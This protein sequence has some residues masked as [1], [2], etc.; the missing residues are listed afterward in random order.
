MDIIE[1]QTIGGYRDSLAELL[2]RVVEDGASIGFL[3]PLSG[4]AA[5]RYWEEVPAPGVAVYVAV[6]E[7]RVVGSVQLHLC[8][9]QNGSHRAEIAKLMTHPD[10]RQRGI[11]R[12]LMRAVEKRAKQ[13]GRSLLVL[14]TRKGDPSNSLYQSLG[15]VEAGEIPG[16]AQSADGALHATVFYYK[17]IA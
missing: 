9:K 10:F 15:F 4:A 5:E 14:D 6:L 13:E 8:L 2:V 17:N 16:Y 3:P 7:G 12:A 1:L 11:G